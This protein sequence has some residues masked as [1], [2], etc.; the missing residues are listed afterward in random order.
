MA[1]RNTELAWGPYRD[2][3]EA[4]SKTAEHQGDDSHRNGEDNPGFWGPL[5]A[6]AQESLGT[7]PAPIVAQ[8]SLRSFLEFVERMR[9]HNATVHFPKPP[10]PRD[11][12]ARERERWKPFRLVQSVGQGKVLLK[13]GSYHA[14]FHAGDPISLLKL[15]ELDD[16]RG[17][18]RGEFLELGS[19]SRL[20]REG[21]LTGVLEATLKAAGLE[22]VCDGGLRDYLS[23]KR[24][25][26][27]RQQTAFE[28]VPEEH[29]A[30]YRSFSAMP[31]SLRRRLAKEPSDRV[32]DAL[33]SEYLHHRKRLV[34]LGLADKL[35]EMQAHDAALLACKQRAVA[36]QEQG[37]GKTRTCIAAAVLSGCR[38]ILIVCYSRLVAVWQQ[39]FQTLGLGDEVQLVES[40]SDISSPRR[41]HIVSYERL[42]ISTEHSTDLHCQVCH[43]PLSPGMRRCPAC[44][45]RVWTQTGCRQCGADPDKLVTYCR[46]CGYYPR[47]YTPP[48]YRAMRR[49]YS[50]A[51]FDESQA[52][53]SRSA[54]RSRACAAIRTRRTLLATGTILENA[55]YEAF[56]QLHLL[57]RGSCLLPYPFEGG[58]K[59][60]VEEFAIVEVTDGH[61]KI[62]PGVKNLDRW[63]RMMDWVMIRRSWADPEVQETLPVPT[64]NLETVW[65]TPTEAE[66]DLYDAMQAGFREWYAAR[67]AKE[68]KALAAK[69]YLLPEEQ[70]SSVEIMAQ[71]TTLLRVASQPWSFEWYQGDKNT[72]KLRAV[73]SIVSQAVKTG[74]KVVLASWQRE[75]VEELGRR[76]DRYGCGVIRG[77][78][79]IAERNRLIKAF[80]EEKNP[81]VL[82]VT[83]GAAGL[84]I[85][86][87]RATTV[88]LLD[89][90]W[91]PA[92]MAQMWK[93]ACN[94]KHSFAATAK[95]CFQLQSTTTIC[96]S[97]W[98]RRTHSR[99]IIIQL[100]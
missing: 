19:L 48:L 37:L 76:L 18:R 88:V 31:R 56:W 93:R 35:N 20:V 28:G 63:H 51:I 9:S 89:L 6:A 39:E 33:R 36:A 73:D 32:S 26:L 30:E 82:A 43:G 24:L 11:S 40:R 54:Q 15:V 84:G 100:R 83:T 65:V 45:R 46:N 96:G 97:R 95:L 25:H 99:K 91:S 12:T 5:F 98:W 86:L 74:E 94:W 38:S 85:T 61:R 53:K 7:L 8:R 22:V 41:F 70:L 21:D 78:V 29:R 10:T 1:K 34:E 3:A 92:A 75:V 47:V 16:G 52:A 67:L 44:R 42:A 58:E 71:L 49:R 64:A 27:L 14:L 72:S 57:F 4:R 62:V 81:K 17:A 55:V 79:P 13:K 90:E 60:F 69:G 59:R 23:I 50:M 68:Q 66:A 80:Q 87:T 77:D 2:W